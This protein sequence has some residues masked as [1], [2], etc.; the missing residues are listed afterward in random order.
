MATETVEKATESAGMP[1]LDIT[2]FGNQ[3]FWL[4]IALI[5]IFFVL[6]RIALPR[7][8]FSNCRGCLAHPVRLVRHQVRMAQVNV[9][10]I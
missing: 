5:V 8:G 7:I 6:S 1:Q 10:F 4:V 9:E 2:T 3:I